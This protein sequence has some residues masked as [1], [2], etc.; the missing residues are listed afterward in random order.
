[1]VCPLSCVGVS[2]KT[3]GV[4]RENSIAPLSSRLSILRFLFIFSYPFCQN[5]LAGMARQA[6]SFR[7][8][9]VKQKYYKGCSRSFQSTSRE[10][11]FKRR[12]TTA[13][14]RRPCLSM[15]MDTRGRRFGYGAATDYR[16]SPVTCRN[17]ASLPDYL[18]C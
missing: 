1:M 4:Q 3:V 15:E 18:A 10:A 11:T 14:K 5:F 7:L 2:A 6:L 9:K 17:S 8:A 16:S 12:Q 13:K